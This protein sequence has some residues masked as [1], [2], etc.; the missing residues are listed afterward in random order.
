MNRAIL[1]AL[2]LATAWAPAYGRKGP[3][4]TTANFLKIGVGPRPAALGGAF[5]GLADDVNALFYNPGG[6]GMLQRQEATFMHHSFYEGVRQEWGAYALPTKRFGT[7]AGSFDMVAVSPFNAYDENDIPMGTVDSSERAITLGYGREFGASRWL[8]LGI[9]GKHIS[10]RLWTYTASAVA[11]DAGVLCRFG[12]EEEYDTEYRLGGAL[13]NLGSGLKYVSESFP[14]PQSLNVG[15]SRS[16]PLP[17]PFEDVRMVAMLEGILPNDDL[18]Y[19][20]A[21]I[22]MKLVREFSIRVGYRQNQ[23]AGTGIA[24]GIGFTSLSRGFTAEWWPEISIDYAF[25]DYG[26]LE[27]SHRIGVTRAFGGNKL[28][29]TIKPSL[30]DLYSR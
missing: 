20:A 7:I 8:S 4:S 29:E 6:L 11:V 26:K 21:G 5:V 23:D 15:A 14:L 12:R 17:H 28:G 1:S 30:Y 19:A 18:P 13:R 24:A 22:E 16:G 25:A 3:G 2:L 27:M 9:A 10:S